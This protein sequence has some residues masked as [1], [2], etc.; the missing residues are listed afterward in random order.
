MD[1]RQQIE[2]FVPGNAQ[3]AADRQ[4]L[5]QRLEEP[6]VFTRENLAGHFT[7]SG[8]VV[9]PDRGSVLMIYH[10]IYDSWSWMGGHADGETDL[11]AVAEREV[12]EESGIRELELLKEGIFSLEVLTVDG[13]EK[14]GKYV[15]SHLHYNVTYLF[16]ADTNQQT[17]S[18][19]EEN[20]GV[21]WIRVADLPKRVSEPWFLERIYSKLCDKVRLM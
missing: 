12:R 3:E 1:L 17:A 18:N 10:N 4:L 8:W 16:Q 21:Q 19:P 5:L 11:R 6:G 7:A 13:H 2:A 14:R 15:S 9:S 20:S